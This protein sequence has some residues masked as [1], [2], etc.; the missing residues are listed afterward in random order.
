ML[1]NAEDHAHLQYHLGP[2]TE[3]TVYKGKVVGLLLT[4]HLLL[5]LH[6]ILFSQ[7]TLGTDNQASIRALTN[8]R[9]HPAHYLTDHVHNTI[10]KLQINQACLQ[11]LPLPRSARHRNTTVPCKLTKISVSWTPGHIGFKPNERADVLAKEAA[12]GFLSPPPNLPPPFLSPNPLPS[13]IPAY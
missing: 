3:H 6:T 4:I 5:S 13:S 12:V 7:I 10:E 9:P 8:Q 11:G 1:V 2:D